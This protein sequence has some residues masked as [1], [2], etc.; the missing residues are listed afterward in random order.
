MDD[1]LPA[2]EGDDYPV[3]PCWEEGTPAPETAVIPEAG[4]PPEL[5]DLLTYMG[6][7]FDQ[8]APH[9]DRYFARLRELLAFHHI[10][11]AAASLD[12]SN[13]AAA[14]RQFQ[15]AAGLTVDGV[16]GQDT[17]WALQQDW[18]EARQLALVNVAA[19]PFPGGGF[20]TFRVRADVVP[21][22]TALRAEAQQLGTIVTSSGSLRDLNAPITPGRS[23]TSLH[24]TG[25]ALDL[26]INSGMQ[27]PATD[28]YVI[29]SAGS[30]WQFWAR[31]NG[32]VQR[33]VQGVRWHNKTTSTQPVSASL[34]DFTA[35][36]Q[37]HGFRTIPH[38][39][40]FPGEYT[41]AEWWHIQA[42]SVLVPFISQFGAELAS[43]AAYS[44]A[45]LQAQP[46]IWANRK[47]IFQRVPTGWQ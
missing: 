36:V 41:C 2:P 17:L 44:L 47:L 4:A 3:P 16:P 19:D 6:V 42:D 24:Y 25:V 14:V 40:C 15:S 38:R 22:Y 28:P 26:F 8:F 45:A 39:G 5:V 7:G 12:R 20:N 43:L 1:E 13:F 37:K 31:G 27:N 21:L 11:G 18:A 46:P 10:M 9:E 23:P 35:L 34:I 33:T 29:A 32:G 30:G